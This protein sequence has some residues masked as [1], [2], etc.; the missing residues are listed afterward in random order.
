MSGGGH[1]MWPQAGC[2]TRWNGAEVSSLAQTVLAAFW[3]LRN[4]HEK[5]LPPHSTSQGFS[6]PSRTGKRPPVIY[7][8]ASGA[9]GTSSFLA[10]IPESLFAAFFCSLSFLAFRLALAAGSRGTLF[11]F[12]AGV[13]VAGGVCTGF[14]GG[15]TGLTAAGPWTSSISRCRFL[16]GMGDLLEVRSRSGHSI[17]G[18]GS[19]S[20]GRAG[21]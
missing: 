17:Q 21:I 13:F 5:K 19:R 8:F 12:L 7:G 11:F 3:P 2:K 10:L 16:L 1:D 14:A 18:R 15:A 20:T 4:S 6:C 9:D